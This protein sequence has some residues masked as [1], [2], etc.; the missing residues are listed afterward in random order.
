MVV[1]IVCLIFIIIIA[2]T[3]LLTKNMYTED[4]KY[5]DKKTYKLREVMPTALFIMDKI[6]NNR[7]HP[8]RKV[9]E[10]ILLIYGKR[11][12]KFRLKMHEAEKISLGLIGVVAVLFITMLISISNSEKLSLLSNTIIRPSAGS[13]NVEY[14]LQAEIEFQGEKEVKNL[15]VII[16]EESPNKEIAIKK[17]EEVASLLPNIILGNNEN[18]SVVN[19]KLAFFTYYE[20]S[21]IKIDW[22]VD[23]PAYIN[24]NGELKYYNIEPKGNNAQITANLTYAGEK[25]STV[26]QLKVYPRTITRKEKIQLIEEALK[27]QLQRENL[28][29]NYGDKITLPTNVQG[30]EAN[31][32]WFLTSQSS[33]TL[34]MFILGILVVILL[35]LLKDYDIK[36]KVEERNNQIRRNFPEFVIKIT[37]LINAGM[38]LSRAWKKISIDYYN[39]TCYISEKE[40]LYEEMLITLQEVNNGVSEIQAYEDFGKRCKIPEMMRFTTVIIQNLRKGND[41]LVVTL[42]NQA[43]E[44]WEIRKNNAKKAGEKA[45]S[46]LLLPMGIMFIIILLLVMMP[47]FMSLN[48]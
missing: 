5:V 12:C 25:V 28:L 26:I 35:V 31:I 18:L 1:S 44:A 13:G 27:E 17:L 2:V 22:I 40:F 7:L 39:Q 41:R 23:T 37:L 42:Q 10:N 19:K 4:M 33:D 9:R 47:A 21:N 32:S 14:N 30:Y 3:F 29:K 38:T 20:Q 46:K 16:P 45:S 48:L 11:E 24:N 36:K 43:N 8:N 34:K 6:F 15:K